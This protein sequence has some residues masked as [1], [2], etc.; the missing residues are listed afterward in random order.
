MK[1][2]IEI[3]GEHAWKVGKNWLMEKGREKGRKEKSQEASYC[4]CSPRVNFRTSAGNVSINYIG[5]W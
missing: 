1:Q 4:K 2:K 3:N 5:I